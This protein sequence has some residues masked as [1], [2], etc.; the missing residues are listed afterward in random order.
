MTS[1]AF[2][3][4]DPRLA[5]AAWSRLVEPGDPLAGW[6]VGELGAPGALRWLLTAVPDP[7]T[8]VRA[9]LGPPGRAVRPSA[10]SAGGSDSGGSDS[11]GPDSGGRRA[12]AARLARA[13]RRWAVRLD[14]LDPRRELRVL[15][16]LGGRLLLPDDQGWPAGLEDLTITAPF[17]L[18]V[19]GPATLAALHRA[20]V[21][22]V[23]AR[24]STPY[25]EQVA[26]R[27]AADLADRHVAVVSG[28]AYG[29]DAAAHR[30]ALSTGGVTVA[31]LAGGV[32]RLYP[33]GN[34]RLLERVAADGAVVSEVPPGS[35]PS[36]MRFLQRNR[37]I[38]AAAG[39]CVVVEA[40][41]R[42]G[43]LSTAHHAAGLLRPLGAVPGPVTSMTSAGCHR[44]LRAGH[45]VCVTDAAE[46]L[47]LI[48]G[49]GVDRDGPSPVDEHLSTQE[50]RAAQQRSETER[51]LLDALPVGRAAGLASIARAAG[52]A[53][54]EVLAALGHLE[55]AGLA[56]REGARW[57]RPRHA[58]GM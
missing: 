30:G 2:D 4:D 10:Q 58:D 27:L 51:R 15:D 19:R 32:D 52:L 53:E 18:W 41:W 38:A 44:L 54:D 42:S 33:A 46:V 25:G 9:L 7:P 50:R 34:T 48:D 55:L 28:G 11:G 17:C 49:L 8:A 36:R 35:V 45:A 20:S 43:A 14:R 23:G 24:A 13:V 6:V 57:R 12:P 1:V 39:A 37:L 29:V 26:E 47:E 31:V 16:R 3:L 56:V 22:I 5:A 21:A 40:A